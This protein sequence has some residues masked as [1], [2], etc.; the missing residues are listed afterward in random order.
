MELWPV[1]KKVGRLMSG[2]TP[3]LQRL[4]VSVLLSL[5][6]CPSFQL[7]A[8]VRATWALIDAAAV[9][10]GAWQAAPVPP[11]SV[12]QVQLAQA[13]SASRQLYPGQEEQTGFQL[14]AAAADG[15]LYAIAEL[16]NG[17]GLT[18][19]IEDGMLVHT[20]DK[21]YV[22]A[23]RLLRS[24]DGGRS[25][26][27]LYLQLGSPP[28]AQG[29]P[30]WDPEGSRMVVAIHPDSSSQVYI[31]TNR[32]LVARSGPLLQGPP[33]VVRLRLP[34]RAGKVTALRTLPNPPQLLMATGNDTG[35]TFERPFVAS[36]TG[37]YRGMIQSDGYI[38]WEAIDQGLTET[39]T[40]IGVDP[41]E[42]ARIYVQLESGAVLTTL[43]PAHSPP[44]SSGWQAIQAAALPAGTRLRTSSYPDEVPPLDVSP[45]LRVSPEYAPAYLT[46]SY[47]MGILLFR[48]YL[49]VEDGGTVYAHHIEDYTGGLRVHQISRSRTGGVTWEGVSHYSLYYNELGSDNQMML[50][51]RDP[52]GG[53]RTIGKTGDFTTL[54]EGLP[55][56]AADRVGPWAQDPIDPLTYYVAQF[57]EGLVYQSAGDQWQ[58][59][60]QGLPLALRIKGIAVDSSSTLYLDT[61]RGLFR[62]LATPIPFSLR[63]VQAQPETLYANGQFRVSAR[64][65]PRTPGAVLPPHTVTAEFQ[66]QRLELGAITTAADG[67]VEYQGQLRVP[68]VYP[69]GF[70]GVYVHA[71]GVDGQRAIGRAS[72]VVFPT[73]SYPIYGDGVEAGWSVSEQEGD[74]ALKAVD[75][76]HTGQFSHRL[77]GRVVY[78]FSGAPIERF[79][80]EVEFYLWTQVVDGA[81]LKVDEYNLRDH[82]TVLESGVWNHVVIPAEQLY[83][84]PPHTTLPGG[85]DALAPHLQRLAFAS[86]QTIFIDDLRLKPVGPLPEGSSLQAT[87]ESDIPDSV[88]AG[89]PFPLRGIVRVTHYEET[90]E[91]PQ[92]TADLSSLGGSAALPLIVEGG[93][94]YR[95]ETALTDTVVGIGKIQITVRQQGTYGLAEVPFIDLVTVLPAVDLVI[96]KDGLDRFWKQEPTVGTAVTLESRDEVFEGNKALKVENDGFATVALVATA[97][98]PSRGY[99]SLHFA[100]HLGDAGI[101]G[102]TQAN[103]AVNINGNRLLSLASRVVDGKAVIDFSHRE[104]QVIEVP[105]SQWGVE[106]RE[107]IRELTFLSNLQGIFYLDDIRLVAA[108]PA[109]LPPTVVAETRDVALPQNFHLDP[110]FPN[111]FNPSTTIRFALTATTQVELALYNLA[112]QRV[113]K[114]VSGQREAGSYSVQWDGRDD[115]GHELASGVYLYR[116]QAGLQV[117]IR[118][119]LLLR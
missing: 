99:R 54:P 93:G 73:A 2:K 47:G 96:Y 111:P 51:L 6:F 23:S 68:K 80:Y 113:A 31:G 87:W 82:G 52:R 55:G 21:P 60:G 36:E 107:E 53:V 13:D 81:N 101:S 97:P 45:F 91:P 39:I 78:S 62:H 61:D 24:L 56:I 116:L 43:L 106:E 10:E 59:I 72:F 105:L 98:A 108:R 102:N 33:R 42:P 38:E 118:N 75:Q 117:E 74:S 7:E 114:L 41:R 65:V 115:Q 46:T 16:R 3:L 8:K 95:L 11:E 112:G 19:L 14:I 22:Q 92:V 70:D 5:V 77:K 12:L 4:M 1:Q 103:F 85:V 66:G 37:L 49:F 34:F 29:T 76:V 15:L 35:A 27:E 79:A 48:E 100:L 28:E 71:D 67:S 57:G 40:A 89:V 25:W 63:Q 90:G 58:D 17:R 20:K 32:G 119:L 88:I 44:E 109:V 50:L 104:W 30:D 84:R 83:Q 64:L 110:N 86:E 18:N 9:P 69:V 26:Q 94:V